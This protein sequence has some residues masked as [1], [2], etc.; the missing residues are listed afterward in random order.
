MTSNRDPRWALMAEYECAE[1]L[2]A[3]AQAAHD[4]G[5]RQ[6][7][8]YAPYAVEGLSEAIGFRRSRIPAFVLIG[9]L[10]GG[11]GGYFMQW[12]AAVRSYPEEIGARPLHSWPMF[13]PVT[14][15][16]T[17][18]AAAL[19]AFCAVLLGNG[20]PRL[21]HPIFDAPDFD[22]A[23]RNRFFLCLRTDDPAFDEVRAGALLE[24][25]S[26]LRVDEVAR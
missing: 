2:V 13:I 3:A 24:S 19:T 16:M 17:I 7:E 6:A 4:A 11:A 1:G 21:A 26:P 8:A 5:Y 10:I 25:T 23:T 14:F 12:Y 18:L 15:E 22:L 20:L 9:G